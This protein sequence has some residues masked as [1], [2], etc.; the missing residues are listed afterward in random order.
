LK[1]ETQPQENRTLKLTVE[2]DDERLQP[3]LR[4]AARRISKDYR[5]PGFR[6][7]KAPYE[8]VLRHFGEN[9]IYQTALE[10]LSQS[11]YKEV[12]E[13]ENIDPY[14]PG[15]L[16]DVKFK[17]VVLTYTVPLAPEV[18][19]GD[20]RALRLPF[21]APAVSD[22]A[23]QDQ[24]EHLREHQAVVEPV[25][26]PAELNDVVTLDAKAFLNT[27]EN[28][29]DFLLADQDVALVLDE[30][31]DWPMPGFAQQVVGMS[32]G[33]DRKF[34][35]AFAEDYANE[36]LRGQ[37]AH[38]EVTVKEVKARALPEWNDELARSLGD[39]ESLDALRAKT[40]A[41]L[42]RQA[43]R[44]V[45]RD[46]ADQ[47]INQLVEQ[48]KIDYPPVLLENE[49]DDVLNDLDRRLREQRLTLDDYLKIQNKTK[50]QLREESRPTAE[51]RL[52]RSLAL[53]KIVSLEGLTVSA[54]DVAERVEVLST[55]WGDRADEMRK[56]LA[57]DDSRRMLAVDL[58]SDK[59]V[60]RLVA[61]GKGESVP[62]PA[63]LAEAADERPTLIEPTAEVETEASAEPGPDATQTP[64]AAA[65][66][67]G[68]APAAEAEAPE[69]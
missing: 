57:S 18:D 3:A 59:A 44:Q 35:L 1:I 19:L 28:P 50:E 12:L 32:A 41:D 48:A 43:S 23:V 52:K 54:E 38:F 37:V 33:S 51:T 58:L 36:S 47:V 25:E 68:P 27:G 34:D 15:E 66:T 39:F 4:A 60:E 7:G 21:Q 16:E 62:P 64:E 61:I 49:L 10:D 14:A 69:Q 53:G 65:E 20:Y 46:Y 56:V 45:E 9:T 26:R 6:P 63:P 22:E 24:L 42:E 30:K 31:A 29:S 67:A 13:Q 2:V 11:I 40:R 8:V 17:P 5:I 55:P